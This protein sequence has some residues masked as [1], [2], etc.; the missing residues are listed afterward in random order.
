[1]GEGNI[2]KATADRVTVKIGVINARDYDG[3]RITASVPRAMGSVSPATGF[4][5]SWGGIPL[6]PSKPVELE[7]LSVTTDGRAYEVK[8]H[9]EGTIPPP[10]GAPD[11]E[12]AT[13]AATEPGSPGLIL[14]R[15]PSRADIA[16]ALRCAAV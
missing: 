5:A 11:A 6:T 10:E 15:A 12:W 7:V 4:E 8:T 13:I 14:T 2:V 1:M 3:Y 16:K 9:F